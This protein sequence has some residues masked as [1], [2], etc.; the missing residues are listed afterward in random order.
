MTDACTYCASDVH[1]HEPVFVET[2]ADGE[3]TLEGQFC[4]HACLA[5]YIDE[6]ELTD[7]ASCAI[8]LED[9]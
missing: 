9:I 4:N 3:R 6:N 2:M 7:G 8:D 5:A 1:R